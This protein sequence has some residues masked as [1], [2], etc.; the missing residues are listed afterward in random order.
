MKKIKIQAVEGRAP[1]FPESGRPVPHSKF[2]EVVETP[3][4]KRM[5]KVGDIVVQNKKNKPGGKD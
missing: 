2:V 3:Q 5:I 1:C 4:I